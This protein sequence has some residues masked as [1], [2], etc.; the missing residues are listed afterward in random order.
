MDGRLRGDIPDL[1]PLAG[2][3]GV[4][5]QL[6][7]LGILKAGAAWLP[8]DPSL[9]TERLA[10]I[11]ED[12]GLAAL[13][14]VAPLVSVLPGWPGSKSRRPSISGISFGRSRNLRAASD[15]SPS[16]SPGSTPSARPRS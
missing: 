5:V 4:A 10:A 2:M 3:A 12:A 11:A 7:I 16:S 8:L 6:A 9:P 1:G 14:T 15:V 13:V